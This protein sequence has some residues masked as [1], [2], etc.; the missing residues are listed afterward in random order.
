MLNTPAYS[1]GVL[2]QT[3][4]GKAT[5]EVGNILSGKSQPMQSTSPTGNIIGGLLGTQ[6]TQNVT[7]RPVS[8]ASTTGSSTG[9]SSPST[10]IGSNPVTNAQ[11]RQ[12][13][14]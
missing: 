14:P 11:A 3:Q 13:R 4:F 7:T 6:A 8:P 9:S 1:A 2:S 5:T 12:G 10:Y